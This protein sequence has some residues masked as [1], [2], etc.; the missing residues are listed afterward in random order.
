MV[1]V[2]EITR[3]VVVLPRSPPVRV[4][5]RLEESTV[6]H[7]LSLSPVSAPFLRNARH[8]LPFLSPSTLPRPPPF[9]PRVILSACA[10]S[11]FVLYLGRL[12]RAN[13]TFRRHPPSG[14]IRLFLYTRVMTRGKFSKHLYT[15]RFPNVNMCVCVCMSVYLICT[16]YDTVLCS[17]FHSRWYLVCELDLYTRRKCISNRVFYHII[18]IVQVCCKYYVLFFS[19]FKL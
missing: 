8:F 19:K 7:C 1:R 4:F 14:A 2:A 18:V 6:A 11:L 17:T 16:K 13:T 10:P 15:L 5:V 3:G 12:V 9:F